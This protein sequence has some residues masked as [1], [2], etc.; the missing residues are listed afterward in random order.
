LDELHFF[1]SGSELPLIEKWVKQQQLDGRVFC[2]GDYPSGRA[3]AELMASF[4]LT[5]LPTIGAEGAP[6]VLLESMACGVP[7]VA[8]NVGGIADYKNKDC[9]ICEPGSDFI[10]VVEELVKK[11]KNGE[12]N[13]ERL[14]DFYDTEY[15][16]IVLT[17]KWNTWL[18]R[19]CV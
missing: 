17:R 9:I 1:G 3:F 15:S 7:F 14:K 11:I 18:G 12:I 16:N 19:V 10:A 6:L 4:D 13:R 2:H 8:C 5:L